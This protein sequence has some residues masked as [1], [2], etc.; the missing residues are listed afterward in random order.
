MKSF[1]VCLICC[2]LSRRFGIAQR[3]APTNKFLEEYQRREERL[4][5]EDLMRLIVFEAILRN[6]IRAEPR[7]VVPQTTTGEPTQS[8][9]RLRSPPLAPQSILDISENRFKNAIIIGILLLLH[10]ILFRLI[11]FSTDGLLRIILRR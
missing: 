9:M 11:L 8:A 5:D 4:D 3:V 7:L 10:V 2:L 1:N 6:R